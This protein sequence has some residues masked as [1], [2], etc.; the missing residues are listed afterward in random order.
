M[1]DSNISANVPASL[2]DGQRPPRSHP[3][4][5]VEISSICGDEHFPEIL[6]QIQAEGDGDGDRGGLRSQGENT[7]KDNAFVYF[8]ALHSTLLLFSSLLSASVVIIIISIIMLT[9]Q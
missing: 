3:F 1:Q 4:P 6:G 5:S 7:F 9:R 2:D 8:S